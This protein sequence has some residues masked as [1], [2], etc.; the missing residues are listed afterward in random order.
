MRPIKKRSNNPPYT[1]TKNFTFSGAA[2]S[3]VKKVLAISSAN[4]VPIAD[5]LDGWLLQV[6]GKKPLGGTLADQSRAV[7]AIQNH[8]GN[9]YKL[10]SVPL[11]QELGAFC[12]FCETPLSG[13]L[14]VEHCAPKSEYPTFALHWDNFLL[15]CSACNIGKGNTPSRSVVRGWVGKGRLTEQQYYDEIRQNHYVWADLETQS[16]RWLP[17]Q[18]EYYDNHSGSWNDV[19]MDKAANPENL[20]LSNEL[21]KREVVARIYDPNDKMM[22]TYDDYSV[23]IVTAGQSSRAQE[24]IKLCKLNEN[25]KMTSTYDRRVTNRTILWFRCLYALKNYYAARTRGARQSAWNLL[26]LAA[27]GGGFFSV[28]LT[29][30]NYHDPALSAKFVADSLAY[31]PNTDPKDLP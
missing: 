28:W 13:L 4:K 15:A 16:Y 2:A 1:T 31:Y 27:E 8:V 11:T 3:V 21:A 24:M 25:G 6:M 26:L 29:V 19:Q 5:C 30:L 9:T 17:L 14:E 22:K 12:S 18:M 20:V 10:A 7:K 23:R